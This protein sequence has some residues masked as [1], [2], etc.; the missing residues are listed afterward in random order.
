MKKRKKRKN[1]KYSNKEKEVLKNIKNKYNI[2]YDK[3]INKS[4]NND[5]SNLEN[6]NNY[7]N[8]INDLNYDN[9]NL[10]YNNIIY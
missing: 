9:N 3:I 6:N 8:H 5:T 1:I 10:N 4:F 7:F 2:D